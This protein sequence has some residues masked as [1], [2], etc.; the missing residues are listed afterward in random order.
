MTALGVR[1]LAAAG[2]GPPSP[3][4]RQARHGPPPDGGDGSREMP[5]VPEPEFTSYYGRPVV[6]PAP[7]GDDVAA[8]LFLGGV[9]G[10]SALLAAGGAAHRAADAAPQLPGWPPWPR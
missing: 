10:G 5:M 9:A 8:Y 1:Q 3:A 4:G 7:W 2:A 6:K